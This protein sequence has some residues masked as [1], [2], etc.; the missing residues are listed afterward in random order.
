MADIEGGIVLVAG[1]A[2]SDLRIGG[3][4]T[5]PGVGDGAGPGVFKVEIETVAHALLVFGEEGV[6]GGVAVE[7]C[8][9]EA[10]VE[11]EV[12]AG[13]EIAAEVGIGATLVEIVAILEGVAGG[14]EVD[15]F[16]EAAAG[17][18]V[19]DGEIP[20]LHV[21]IAA[22]GVDEEGGGVA[23]VGGVV[24]IEGN[25]GLAGE[26][27]LAHLPDGDGV[28]EAG[29]EIDTVIEGGA[30]HGELEFDEARVGIVVTT[31]GADDGAGEEVRLPGET[32]AGGEV[33]PVAGDDAGIDFTEGSELEQ[34]GG[35][36]EAVRD[37]AGGALG[38]G[39]LGKEVGDAVVEGEIAGDLPGVLEVGHG[40]G[41][42]VRQHGQAAVGAGGGHAE[43]EVG[44]GIAAIGAEGGGA[45]LGIAA[46]LGGEGA[47]EAEGADGAGIGVLLPGAAVTEGG[48][49]LEVVFA[50]DE[51][52][53]FVELVAVIEIAEVAIGAAETAVFLEAHAG[54]AA[55]VK[56]IDDAELGGDGAEFAA[57]IGE[58]GDVAD[59]TEAEGIDE[60][61]AEGPGVLEHAVLG[62]I[63]V[64][65]AGEGLEG[66][67]EGGGV[68]VEP[69]AVE[70]LGI[71]DGV[72][73]AEAPLVVIK[74]VAGA[75]EEILGSLGEAGTGEV[76]LLEAVG[77]GVDAVGGDGLV[78]ESGTG[79]GSGVVGE[80]IVDDFGD[81]G[82]VAVEHL[83]GGS[84]GTG[85]EGIDFAEAFV[86][87]VEPEFVLLDGAADGATVL[88]A[89]EVFG[90]LGE[91]VAGVE[92]AVAD[93][94]EGL[95]VDVVG[96]ALG[97]DVDEAGVGALVGHEEA[98]LDLE[99]VDG[100]DGE[101]HG[102]FTEA[103]PADGDA[104]DEVAG[105]AAEVAGD[106]DG[107]APAAD[108][109]GI[110]GA[111]GGFIGAGGE[112]GELEE[113]AAVEGE[114]VDALGVHDGADGIGFRFEDDLAVAGDG[115]HVAHLAE[116]EGG[117]EGGELADLDLEAG[118]FEG[119]EAVLG[120]T[121]GVGSGGDGGEDKAA[122]FV[123]F[124][125]T[126]L[127]TGGVDEAD[128]GSGD[129][130]TGVI[131]NGTAEGGGAKGGL[132]ESREREGEPE[133]E[134]GE[135]GQLFPSDHHA[136][137]LTERRERSKV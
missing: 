50:L 112:E 82:E 103:A 24:L 125:G 128:A 111:T 131:G 108:L 73:D 13:G 102:K 136:G 49:E 110:V 62:F 26:D 40:L 100:G 88:V 129:E 71:G 117:G 90:D 106:D 97:G 119:G 53:A 75:T 104:I 65:S 67:L 120:N 63:G 7:V 43:E 33:I 8:P 135:G 70:L 15:K 17:E 54:N 79:V 113:V 94:P 18:A 78:G 28:I 55:G 89:F 126:S 45:A 61:G 52:Q 116:L 92:F 86:V 77:D 1:A 20:L 91:V 29:D 57:F 81:F 22:L 47:L 93:E 68:L 122:G 80:R 105:S 42:A 38:V 44:E 48:T 36:I 34:A 137:I 39:N 115:D 107:S 25:A 99:L 60:G 27:V 21:G 12:G 66:A 11:G 30:D 46:D 14:A 87:G 58:E 109:I 69:L 32:E 130:S 19:L 114:G 5:F 127:A 37:F 10:G 84:E 56:G 96:A 31:A 6:V 4:G 95:A 121:D 23:E 132:G 2:S 123:R 134:Q 72:I 41:E 51:V 98:L 74:S 9:E 124:R 35:F 3:A 59:G 101:I 85:T 16:E 83:G 133:S 118:L 64:G 76:K